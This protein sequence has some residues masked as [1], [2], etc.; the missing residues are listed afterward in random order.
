MQ[1]ELEKLP[2]PIRSVGNVADRDHGSVRYGRAPDAKLLLTSGMTYY[3]TILGLSPVCTPAFDM[4]VS[5]LLGL[6]SIAVSSGAASL[7]PRAA[8]PCSA[9]PSWTFDSDHHYTHTEANG[10]T[11][12]VHTPSTF[13][14]TIRHALVLS[15]HGYADS[16]A[17]QESVS[18]LSKS[19]LLID[20]KGIIAVYPQGALGPGKPGDTSQRAWQGAPYSAVG[21]DDVCAASTL[22]F[23]L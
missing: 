15:F 13:D 20:G 7:P 4:L 9:T 14:P 22:R 16:A 18:G 21:V 12:L 17:G 6:S 1:D 2:P 23:A 11:Y 5:L 19:G 3:N 8:N 10:R